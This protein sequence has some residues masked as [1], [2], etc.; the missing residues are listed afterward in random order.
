M[1]TPHR[2]VQ[3]RD[4]RQDLAEEDGEILSTRKGV[5]GKV[6]LNEQAK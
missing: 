3:S 4:I 6:A 5:E 1:C 2:F